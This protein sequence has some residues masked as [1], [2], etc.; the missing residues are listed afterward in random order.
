MMLRPLSPVSLSSKLDPYRF[1]MLISVSPS[2]SPTAA[3]V[4][5]STVTPTAESW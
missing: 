4:S 1:S 5:R 3:P 2:A